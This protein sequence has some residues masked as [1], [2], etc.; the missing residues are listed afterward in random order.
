MN[1]RSLRSSA[2]LAGTFAAAAAGARTVGLLSGLVHAAAAEVRATPVTGLLLDLVDGALDAAEK[3]AGAVDPTLGLAMHRIG[4]DRDIHSVSPGD[5]DVP[6]AIDVRR[7]WRSVGL[8][9]EAGLLT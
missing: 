8:H 7:R 3:T 6:A 9:H 2:G 4:Y 1:G 5:T